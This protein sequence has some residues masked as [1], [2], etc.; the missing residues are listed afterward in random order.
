MQALLSPPLWLLRPQVL[1]WDEDKS[2][3]E[4]AQE[5]EA[6]LEDNARLPPSQ[7]LEWDQDGDQAPFKDVL[8]A[9]HAR[10][11]RWRAPRLATCLACTACLLRRAPFSRPAAQ[12]E[13]WCAAMHAMLRPFACGP[14]CTVH[15]FSLPLSL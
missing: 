12:W 7:Q 15:L 14:P 11:V 9:F 10:W 3:K 13:L 6:L 5:I 1:L 8:D 2:D 4:V